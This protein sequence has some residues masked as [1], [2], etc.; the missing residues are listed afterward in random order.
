MIIR[1][2]VVYFCS[3]FVDPQKEN[4]PVI[5][6]VVGG[7]GM[8]TDSV[9]PDQGV[10]LPASHKFTYSA[11]AGAGPP[12]QPAATAPG[13]T[14]HP[15]T[16]AQAASPTAGKRTFSD[17][18]KSPGATEFQAKRGTAAYQRVFHIPQEER[19]SGLTGVFSTVSLEDFRSSPG[20]AQGPAICSPLGV[21]KNLLDELHDA[22]EEASP[23]PVPEDSSF[24][25]DQ[26]LC[27]N[28]CLDSDGSL[29]ESPASGEAS[30]S[31]RRV[32]PSPGDEGTGGQ[33]AW[34]EPTPQRPSLGSNLFR[35]GE[36]QSPFIGRTPARGTPPPSAAQS[37]YFLKPRTGVVFRSYCSSINRSTFSSHSVDA[38]DTSSMASFTAGAVTPLQRTHSANDSRYQVGWWW[39]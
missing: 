24:T 1:V 25:S 12:T 36:L 19:R 28:L 37:P 8:K 16:D 30:S 23:P 17:V 20:A 26:E 10:Q 27:R 15:G 22:A 2:Y 3:S 35:R 4:D 39:W 5:N 6:M 21:T 7:T 32:T 11:E 38:M 33:T 13:N 14:P 29:N 9:C 31:P 18:E 34:M